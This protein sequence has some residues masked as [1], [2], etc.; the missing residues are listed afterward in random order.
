MSLHGLGVTGIQLALTPERIWKAMQS[1]KNAGG[2]ISNEVRYEFGL[3]SQ[4]H[5]RW[6]SGNA[7]L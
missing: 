3:A 1:E 6:I 2:S 4:A 7:R 5:V